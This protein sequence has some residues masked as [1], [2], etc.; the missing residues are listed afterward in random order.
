ML[1]S[2]L[3]GPAVER[4]GSQTKSPLPAGS[5]AVGRDQA[6]MHQILRRLMRLGDHDRGADLA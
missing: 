2:R 5:S 6:G 3:S 1:T 4:S